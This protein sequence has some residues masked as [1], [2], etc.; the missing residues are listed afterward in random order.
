[1]TSGTEWQA[2]VGRNWAD[3]Y[4]KTDRSF[5]NLTA[6]LLERLAPLPGT[7]VLA[8][9]CGAGELTLAVA[10]ARPQASVTGVDI[11]EDLITAALER[12]GDRELVHFAVADASA[13]EPDGPAPDLLISRHGVMF[14]PDPPGA[15]AHLRQIAAPGANFAFSCFRTPRENP[16]ASDMAAMLPANGPARVP[17]DPHAP[18]PFAFA[19][20]DHV[21]AI[22]LAGGWTDI[23]FAAFDYSFVAGLGEDPLAD[24]AEFFSRI[25]PAAS[26][27]RQL[28]EGELAAVQGRIKAWLEQH[29]DGNRVAFPAAAWIVTA[30]N[31]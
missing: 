28:P 11:S 14:F 6:H 21:R 16:W 29:R 20:P 5:S 10:S 13:W 4:R 2:A 18:G 15:F 3:M 23:S 31:G 1:M 17:T 25:G 26:A 19:N 9:G 30:R 24:A 8:I 7:A 27:L 22:L 12:A